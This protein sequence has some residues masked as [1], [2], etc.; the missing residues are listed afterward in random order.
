MPELVDTMAAIKQRLQ[1]QQKALQVASRGDESAFLMLRAEMD[2]LWACVEVLAQA[3]DGR[4][5]VIVP[6]Y[7][8][9][10]AEELIRER[11]ERLDAAPEHKPISLGWILDLFR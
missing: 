10:K 9:R 6:E 2:A 1:S 11:R 5:P 8:S 4:D 3:A 7:F